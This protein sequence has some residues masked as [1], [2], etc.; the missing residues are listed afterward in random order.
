MLN[1]SNSSKIPDRI[2]KKIAGNVDCVEEMSSG[3]TIL[4]GNL[5]SVLE[6]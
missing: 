1:Y 5:K 6:P 4:N 3:Y 2:Y